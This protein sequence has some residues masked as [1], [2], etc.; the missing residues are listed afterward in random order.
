MPDAIDLTF[1]SA[2]VAWCPDRGPSVPNE[3]S[4]KPLTVICERTHVRDAPIQPIANPIQPHS[5]NAGSLTLA[6][7]APIR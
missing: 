1:R 3:D 2:R 7:P 6:R 5:K 4:S